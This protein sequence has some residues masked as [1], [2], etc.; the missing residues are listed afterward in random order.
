MSLNR[1]LGKKKYSED[2]NK[3]KSAE[4]KML[5][6]AK[7]QEVPSPQSAAE[8]DAI[9]KIKIR[10]ILDSPKKSQQKPEVVEETEIEEK[11]TPADTLKQEFLAELERLKAWITPRTYLKAD[12]DTAGTMISA[13]AMIYSKLKASG[14]SN[15]TDFPAKLHATS[16]K[17]LYQRVSPDFLPDTPRRALLRFLQGKSESKDTYHIRKIQTEAEEAF[18]KAKTFQIILEL[19]GRAKIVKKKVPRLGNAENESES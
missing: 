14:E 8:R 12:I 4:A 19:I 7:E 9:L 13:I 18:R 17:T 3:S 5:V 11:Q 15:E 1:W 6:G 2:T 10:K 16:T